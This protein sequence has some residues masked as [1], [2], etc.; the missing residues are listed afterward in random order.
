M[1]K[2]SPV[3]SLDRENFFKMAPESFGSIPSRSLTRCSRFIWYSLFPRSL[4]LSLCPSLSMVCILK[5]RLLFQDHS[6]GPGDAHCYW[7]GHCLHHSFSVYS[8]NAT[9]KSKPW[10]FTSPFL[11]CIRKLFTLH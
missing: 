6:L 10:D 4:S 8:D 7:H 2:L 1:F 11:S 3:P 5:W 9:L